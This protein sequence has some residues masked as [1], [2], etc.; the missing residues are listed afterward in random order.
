[1]KRE[2][3][4]IAGLVLAGM[5]A[6]AE[7]VETYWRLEPVNAAAPTTTPLNAPFFEQ[8]LLPVALVSLDGDVSVGQKVILKGT[9]LYEVFNDSGKIGFCTVKERSAANQARTLFI[10]ILD[11]RPCFL[12]SD[13]DGR[14]D[15]VF[16]VFDKYGGP[17]SVRG[18]IDSA[19]PLPSSTAYR[20][21]DIHNF[22]TK[23]TVSF[24]LSGKENISKARLGVRFSDAVGGN[25]YDQTGLMDG[26]SVVFDAMNSHLILSAIANKTANIQISTDGALVISSDN[27]NNLY[28]HRL[29]SFLEAR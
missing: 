10:P 29:P 19:L 17:P 27:R 3:A 1:M 25:W 15:H 24:F 9:L 16:S 14:F 23:I 28:W 7:R 20:S 12:D 8:R 4:T 11:Q 5:P 22:P 21:V 26:S 2:F 18:S 13:R 6:N